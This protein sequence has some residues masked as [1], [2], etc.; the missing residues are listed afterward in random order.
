MLPYMAYIRSRHGY[1]SLLVLYPIFDR[2]SRQ[3]Q[4]LAPNLVNFRPHVFL[5]PF[6]GY[7][8][9]SAGSNPPPPEIY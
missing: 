3:G 6:M 2:R 7:E 1:F 4:D 9:Q 5:N 8:L